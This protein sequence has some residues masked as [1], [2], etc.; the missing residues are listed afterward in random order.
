[1]GLCYSLRLSLDESSDTE[2]PVDCSVS[3]RSKDLDHEDTEAYNDMALLGGCWC[4]RGGP[5]K[6]KLNA[7]DAGR[8][9]TTKGVPIQNG[10]NV[11]ADRSQ[12]QHLLQKKHSKQT[13]GHSMVDRTLIKQLGGSYPLIVRTVIL[14]TAAARKNGPQNQD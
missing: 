7:R 4:R 11:G 9:D 13:Q 12:R 6:G 10:D 14:T 5:S 1:M 2:K 8:G 3:L